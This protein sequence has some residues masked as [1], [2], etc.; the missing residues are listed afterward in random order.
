MSEN[1]TN[2]KRPEIWKIYEWKDWNSKKS[3]D[4]K[5]QNLNEQKIVIFYF[6][7]SFQG[8]VNDILKDLLKSVSFLILSILF[9][10]S[11]FSLTFWIFDFWRIF[12][13]FF[14]GDFLIRFLQQEFLKCP[15]LNDWLPKI[16]RVILLFILFIYFDLNY[17]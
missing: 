16:W 9:C 1:I 8:Y 10:L 2:D 15:N 12:K 7:W 3:F 17:S 11:N 14:G 13:R 4:V 5:P 6:S